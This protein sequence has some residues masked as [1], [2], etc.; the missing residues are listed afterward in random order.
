LHWSAENRA[1]I[2]CKDVSI[3]MSQS[4]W[5]KSLAGQKKLSQQIAMPLSAAS[6]HDVSAVK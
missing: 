5:E 3:P 2:N 1:R 6:G 4:P